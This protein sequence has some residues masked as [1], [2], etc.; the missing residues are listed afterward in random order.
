MKLSKSNVIV[1]VSIIVVLTLVALYTW[2]T[3]KK[4]NE[5]TILGSPAG[6]ALA[7][8]PEQKT[9]TDLSGNPVSID[10]YLGNVLVVNSWAS[11]S[12]FSKKELLELSSLVGKYE[13]VEIL[14]INRAEPATTAE[15]F[16]LSI[17][18]DRNIILIL[19]P[20]D[21]F[22]ESIEGFSMPE[23]VFYDREG[24]IIHHNHGSMTSEKISLYIE[25]ALAASSSE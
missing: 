9:Y 17:N 8:S 10:D 21:R 23:T 6:S 20:A 13:D 11:W 24:N 4:N 16:L 14:A 15:A 18:A 5:N 2:F 12:P 7:S 1:L 19:D 22:Y 3:I 25:K